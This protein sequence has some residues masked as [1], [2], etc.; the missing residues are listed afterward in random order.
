MGKNTFFSLPLE[1]RNQIYCYVYACTLI[2]PRN[3][4]GG[5]PCLSLYPPS[6]SNNGFHGELPPSE[7]LALL[8]VNRQM[9]NEAA[10]I[11][12][13]KTQFQHEAF[14]M[15][16]FIKGIGR[17][18]ANLL[19]NLVLS[20]THGTILKH[21]VLKCLLTLEGLKRILLK[22]Y[23][24][25]F[26]DLK[27]ELVRAGILDFTGRVTISV[28]NLWRNWKKIEDRKRYTKIYHFWSCE[29]GATE[30]KGPEK[31]VRCCF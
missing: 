15:Q 10:A 30:W 17:I 14:Q 24:E 23:V 11:F 22:S 28:W 19:R 2:K 27:N 20:H 21:E 13:G 3:M 7:V 5:R 16:R 6:R 12:Y 4:V 29:K 8:L 18:R 9:L 31:T 26:D 1:I 25:N